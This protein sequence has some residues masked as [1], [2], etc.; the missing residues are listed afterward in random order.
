MASLY[1]AWKNGDLGKCYKDGGDVK[2]LADG[3]LLCSKERLEESYA[4]QVEE[5]EEDAG[6]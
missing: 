5:V 3:T 6:Q 1:S 2:I 4:I